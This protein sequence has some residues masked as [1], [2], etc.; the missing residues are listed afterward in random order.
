[1]QLEDC[2]PFILLVHHRHAFRPLDFLRPLFAKVIM[3]EGF[4]AHPHRGFETVTYV[5]PGR[6]GLVHRDS[7][8]C[9]M[10]YGDGSVQWMTAGRG[11]LHEEM[12]DTAAG[13]DAELYQL[14]VNL[15]PHDKMIPPRVQLLT[16]A[17][18]EGGVAEVLRDGTTPVRVAPIRFEQLDDGAVTVRTLADVGGAKDDGA[19][20]HS[21]MRLLHVEL[22]G[23]SA[24]HDVPLPEGWTC[25][26][27][28]RR[29][30]LTCGADDGGTASMHETVYL[31][32]YG[33]DGLR[34]LNAH[35]G[36]TDVLVLAGEPIGAPVAASGTMVMNSPAE[37]Q[38]ALVDYQRGMFGIPW[39]H[40]LP[41]DDWSQLCAA[42]RRS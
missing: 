18:P 31:S 42:R 13:V 15:P 41:D 28:V 36:L 1:M 39:D 40:K 6:A 22:R 33:G 14:W 37:V 38:Q 10:R 17:E 20:T 25:V 3:P 27:Y 23:E 26:L 11:V 30:R 7:E 4:P 16:P 2:D 9:K 29:G 24:C 8:G 35:A 12:W 34:L 21:P 32:R 19:Q 5:L